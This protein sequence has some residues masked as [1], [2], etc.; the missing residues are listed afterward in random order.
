MCC[1]LTVLS[2]LNRNLQVKKKLIVNATLIGH[3]PS[4]S[5]VLVGLQK[6]FLLQTI[7]MQTKEHVR[8]VHRSKTSQKNLTSFYFLE[9]L[10]R[11][12]FF[13]LFSNDPAYKN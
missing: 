2:T 10:L 7:Y 11:G 13:W 5:L 6:E 4:S 12:L 3:A 1:G 9:V 8:L